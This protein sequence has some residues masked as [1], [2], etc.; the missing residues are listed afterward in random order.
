MAD[1]AAPLPLEVGAPIIA[2]LRILLDDL[3]I[4]QPNDVVFVFDKRVR[5]FMGA[6]PGLKMMHEKYADAF[7]VVDQEAN[8]RYD[9]LSVLRPAA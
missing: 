5:Q 7:K 1:C 3:T 8:I 2:E 6:W 4:A 9:R